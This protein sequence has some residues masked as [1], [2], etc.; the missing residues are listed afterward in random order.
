M[1]GNYA[2]VM[3][4]GSKFIL[5]DHNAALIQFPPNNTLV[6]AGVNDPLAGCRNP[7][8]SCL[9]GGKALTVFFCMLMS[10]FGLMAIG[11][12]MEVM[13][14]A[15]GSGHVI[16]EIIERVPKLKPPRKELKEPIKDIELKGQVSLNRVSFVYPS[17]KENPVF[18]DFDLVIP[19]GQSCALVGTS[20]CGKSTII[21]WV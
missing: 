3:Y 7:A 19:A 15:K 16:F 21:R 1:Y 18:T 13:K 12:A 10:S 6:S 4:F 9:D 11:P 2:I 5:D 17:R 20:G 8:A 14:K